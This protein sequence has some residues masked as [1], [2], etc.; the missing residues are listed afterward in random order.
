M[1]IEFLHILSTEFC[2]HGLMFLN[3]FSNNDEDMIL[4]SCSRQF[5]HIFSY[6]VPS[7]WL[8]ELSP[9]ELEHAS[10]ALQTS[11]YKCS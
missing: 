6:C 11:F 4:L 5:V 3:Y 7:S 10:K 9:S 8:K 1:N 2:S